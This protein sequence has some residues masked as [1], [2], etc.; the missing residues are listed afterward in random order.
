MHWC[1]TRLSNGLVSSITWSFQDFGTSCW[2][3]LYSWQ[4]AYC[5]LIPTI[6]WLN[7]GFS[8]EVS[9]RLLLN[10]T[11]C[12]WW[13]RC[14]KKRMRVKFKSCNGS[15]LITASPKVIRFV[16]CCWISKL[17]RSMTFTWNSCRFWL[18]QILTNLLHP[19]AIICHQLPW[20]QR[21]GHIKICNVWGRILWEFICCFW[22]AT[23]PLPKNGHGNRQCLDY[24]SNVNTTAHSG[25]AWKWAGTLVLTPMQSSAFVPS[26]TNTSF[27]FA[28]IYI[29]ELENIAPQQK[30]PR[31]HTQHTN[32]HTSIHTN[33][34]RSN[35]YK[36]TY[37]HIHKTKQKQYS[38]AYT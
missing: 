20:W 9:S 25:H 11:H 17:W 24:L 16:C 21:V 1:S 2:D 10:R 30:T 34:S 19:F 36:L 31:P 5:I 26:F 15:Y 27:R 28:Y 35:T 14:R 33:Q 7:H 22:K 6:P 29:Y 32:L 12:D 37:K 4:L 38:Q 8:I 23:C 3:S 18:D 13:N